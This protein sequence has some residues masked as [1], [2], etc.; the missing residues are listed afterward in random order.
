MDW[1]VF[2]ENIEMFKWRRINH[3]ETC[4]YW[5]EDHCSHLSRI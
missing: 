4:I 5:D 1:E 2:G 3:T